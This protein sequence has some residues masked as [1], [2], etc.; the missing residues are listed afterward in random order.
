[1][2]GLCLID[3]CVCDCIE[4][5]PSVW[6]SS[7]GVV[8]LCLL[9]RCPCYHC[10]MCVCVCVYTIVLNL[11]VLSLRVGSSLCV[12][13]SCLCCLCYG[14][15]C[16]SVLCVRYLRAVYVCYV[17]LS[18]CIVLCDVVW[19]VCVFGVCHVCGMCVPCV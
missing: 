10:V 7:A 17:K 6:Y 14:C 16:A 18:V 2:C 11:S 12:L 13:Y 3:D 19:R 15:V 8:S 5:Y 1:M 4:R 9:F